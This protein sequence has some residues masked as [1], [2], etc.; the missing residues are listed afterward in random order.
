MSHL[1]TINDKDDVPL[2]IK[3]PPVIEQLKRVNS[4]IEE[5]KVKRFSKL[6]PKKVLLPDVEQTE[7]VDYERSH[8][9]ELLNKEDIKSFAE[10]LS[11]DQRRDLPRVSAYCTCEEFDMNELIKFLQDKHSVYP[12]IF[13]EAIYV[14]YE[15]I[16]NAPSHVFEPEA[17]DNFHGFGEV[18]YFEYGCIVFW[19]FT[20]DQ[21]DFILKELFHLQFNSLK[22]NDIV[23]EDFHFQ[24]YDKLEYSRIYNDMIT[25]K[26]PE[27]MIKLT[28]SHGF[29]QSVKLTL[30]EDIMANTLNESQKVPDELAIHGDIS[31][32]KN[33][34]AKTCGRLYDV[35]MKVNL[36]SSV[37]D[38]PDFFWSNPDL[39]KI[40][41]RIK[42]YMQI[43]N[44]VELLNTRTQVLS[45]LLDM[46]ASHSDGNK[47]DSLTWAIIFL[48]I[49]DI[50]VM[51]IEILVKLLSL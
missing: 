51:S 15:W 50:V 11:S 41:D 48:I 3:S 38:I 22:A 19:N 43:P 47:M 8:I 14:L 1:N 6:N 45:D 23:Y 18:F 28:L 27:I 7:E 10:S 16:Y 30:F 4:P 29:A 37:L 33:Q 25:L 35:K 26:S 44:R 12:R 42:I 40:Y 21:E 24:Y 13:D 20:E 31:F 46:L 9:L 2:L 36:V 17:V 5:K 32:T 34:I 49:A 39:Q